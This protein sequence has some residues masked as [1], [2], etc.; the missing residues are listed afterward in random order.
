MSHSTINFKKLVL[1]AHS[2][3]HRVG[4][5][6]W[7]GLGNHILRV[8]ADPRVSGLSTKIDKVK[9]VIF[10]TFLQAAGGHLRS[11]VRSGWLGPLFLRHW[12]WFGVEEAAFGHELWGRGRKECLQV[13]L[14]TLGLL[15][16]LLTPLCSP[17]PQPYPYLVLTCDPIELIGDSCELFKA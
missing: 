6:P 12:A 10:L 11:A 3:H 2:K 5:R 14:P 17:R 8:Q 15:V 16:S 7:A 9:S 1:D 4:R 13:R